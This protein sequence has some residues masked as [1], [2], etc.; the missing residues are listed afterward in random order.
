MRQELKWWLK[1]ISANSGCEMNER[2]GATLY[3]LGKRE[4]KTGGWWSLHEKGRHIN[5]LEIRAT[6]FRF[7]NKVKRGDRRIRSD[8]TSAAAHINKYGGC[9]SPDLNSLSS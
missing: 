7:A 5:F 9:R 2:M 8:N 6:Q 1:N 3:I 4:G